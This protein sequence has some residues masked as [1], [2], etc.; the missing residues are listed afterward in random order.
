MHL[1]T[2]SHT[3]WFSIALQV[4][5]TA[6]SKCPRTERGHTRKHKRANPVISKLGN[7]LPT[8]ASSTPDFLLQE[9]L[10][11]CSACQASKFCKHWQG[12]LL[13]PPRSFLQ[14]EMYWSSILELR[15]SES[16][17]SL[18]K[19][20]QARVI[21]NPHEPLQPG[22]LL[23]KTLAGQRASILPALSGP[24]DNLATTRWGTTLSHIRQVDCL[25]TLTVRG[26]RKDFRS[27]N[28]FLS[29]KAAMFYL[30]SKLFVLRP[31][32]SLNG[33]VT[34]AV[35]RW[36]VNPCNEEQAF[37]YSSSLSRKRGRN[38]LDTASPRVQGARN[39]SV[40]YTRL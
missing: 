35:K 14:P 40:S 8:P 27:T 33:F 30:H 22:F 38:V 18:C 16:A 4:K 37:N 28:V 1:N 26:Q 9:Q 17:F 15:S 29:F 11:W 3:I 34:K 2:L 23:E 12:S 19:C 5:G 20:Q 31:V 39:R 32:K 21:S 25:S 7:H 24:C 6:S 36:A 10:T 13:T